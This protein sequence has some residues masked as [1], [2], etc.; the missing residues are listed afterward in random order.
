M[1]GFFNLF[2]F[3]VTHAVVGF[4]YAVFCLLHASC[5]HLGGPGGSLWRAE[6]LS[7]DVPMLIPGPVNML[8]LRGKRDFAGAVAVWKTG[9]VSGAG[10]WVWC[11]R[12]SPGAGD[13]WPKEPKT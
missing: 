12:T 2:T 13:A 1:I 3:N 11:S 5:M 9:R 4:L 7:Q 8:T 10:R 6:G